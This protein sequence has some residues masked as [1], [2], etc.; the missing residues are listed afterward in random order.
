MFQMST[1]K[2]KGNIHWQITGLLFFLSS[3]FHLVLRCCAEGYSQVSQHYHILL[4]FATKQ[5]FQ[6]VWNYRQTKTS[7]LASFEFK[8]QLGILA[9]YMLNLYL[10]LQ[11]IVL[12]ISAFGS[13]PS[14]LFNQRK[15]HCP[16]AWPCDYGTCFKKYKQWCLIDWMY[17][18]SNFGIY[19]GQ[20]NTIQSTHYHK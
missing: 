13:F 18:L 11:W 9:A 19:V 8:M 2:W 6:N 10:V 16:Q 5:F 20:K 14:V 17:S 3:T 4:L 12:S 7:Q 1:T 15:V